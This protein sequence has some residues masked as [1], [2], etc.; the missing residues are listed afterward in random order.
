MRI[1]DW[2]SDVC[3]SDLPGLQGHRRS[4]I[5]RKNMSSGLIGAIILWLIVAVIGIAIVVYLLNWLYH[6]S[7]KEV[8]FVRTGYGGETVVINGGALVLP[9]SEERR[10]GKSVSVSVDLGGRRILKKKR[11]TKNQL[12]KK[13]DN[14]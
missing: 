10:E 3:S 2:S 6:R 9:R 7:T 11:R 4:L 1:S 8:S 14:K 13:T 5:G 12:I